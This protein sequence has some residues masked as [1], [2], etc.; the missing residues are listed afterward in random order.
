MASLYCGLNPWRNLRH[1]RLPDLTSPNLC[2]LDY[3]K[4]RV[5]RKKPRNIE[6]LKDNIR[7]EIANT[8]N[9]VLWR[10][11]SNMERRVQVCLEEGD[12]HFII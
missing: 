8:E 6:T 5:Y 11:A 4:E 2:L 1:L 9:G 10:K 7:L 12:N 3:P